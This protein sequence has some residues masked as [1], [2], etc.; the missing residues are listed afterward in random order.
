MSTRTKKQIIALCVTLVLIVSFWIYWSP[1]AAVTGHFSFRDLIAI[2]SLVR[3]ETFES[4]LQITEQP[5]GTVLILT[6]K[7]RAPLDGIGHCFT[8]ERK[9][10]WKITERGHWM[11]ILFDDNTGLLTT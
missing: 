3:S 9:G 2:R 7:Q 10:G 1:R 6:G 11:S 8:V 5:D 4:I